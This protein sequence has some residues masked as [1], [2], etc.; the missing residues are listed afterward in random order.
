MKLT[1]WQKNPMYTCNLLVWTSD[2]NV[3]YVSQFSHDLNL[4]GSNDQ[5]YIA[6]EIKYKKGDSR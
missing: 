5:S 3:I 1:K 6:Y 4:N 2:S